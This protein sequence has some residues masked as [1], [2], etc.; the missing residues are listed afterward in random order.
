MCGVGRLGVLGKWSK[1]H[2]PPWMLGIDELGINRYYRCKNWGLWNLIKLCQSNKRQNSASSLTLNPGSMPPCN[3]VS[4]LSA[5]MH[6]WTKG[7]TRQ[8]LAELCPGKWQYPGLCPQDNLIINSKALYQH[9]SERGWDESQGIV[10]LE[11][12]TL[13]LQWLLKNYFCLDKISNEE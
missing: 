12:A 9:W 2:P 8:S 13:F 7:L 5:E 11:N 3:I 6:M 10:E 1:S 4:V